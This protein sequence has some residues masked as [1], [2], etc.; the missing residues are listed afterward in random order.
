MKQKRND[1]KIADYYEKIKSDKQKHTAYEMIVSVG[2]MNER[3]PEEVG[4]EIL[5]EFASGWIDKNP[6]LIM[7]GCYYHADEQGVPH[8][9][10][11]YIPV[12]TEFR[13]GLSKQVSSTQALKEMGFVSDGCNNTAQTKW[14]HSE[15]ARLEE[16]CNN[17]GI[18]IYHPMNGKE[19]QEKEQYILERQKEKLES[20]ISELTENITE[21]KRDRQTAANELLKISPIVKEIK[22][23]FSKEIQEVENILPEPKR[24][25]SSKEYRARIIPVIEKAIDGI[26]KKARSWH[27]T[28]IGLVK[29][30]KS[31]KE[32][33]STIS[34]K[35]KALTDENIRLKND[36]EDLCYIYGKETVREQLA[37]YRTD[38]KYREQSSIKKPV[39]KS[40]RQER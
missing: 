34:E 12:G 30:N 23:D 15:N 26:I 21:L 16:I 33:N 24:F 31:L 29:E 32:M 2:N 17:H 10:I 9:H 13:K 4:Y 19:H 1:R 36:Y 8:I 14:I 6:N 39:K 11:D 25:E 20:E 37:E 7:F 28:I 22:S 38:K 27:R 5:K 40:S 18:E 3:I 35:I